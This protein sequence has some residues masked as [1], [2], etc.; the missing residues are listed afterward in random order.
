MGG[1]KNTR[2]KFMVVGKDMLIGV[3]ATQGTSTPKGKEV[4]G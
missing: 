2:Q 3:E 4:G 1:T